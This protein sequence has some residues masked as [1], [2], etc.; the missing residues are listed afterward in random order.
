MGLLP[1]SKFAKTAVERLDS[2]RYVI[3]VLSK[4]VSLHMRTKTKLITTACVAALALCAPLSSWAKE[5]KSVPFHGKIS[6][7]DQTAK[8]FSIAGKE[9][10]RVFTITE[11][12]VITKDGKPGT[13]ADLAAEEEVRGSY[14]KR[15]DG[16]IEAKIVKLGQK[17]EAETSKSKKKKKEKTDSET[18]TA[19]SP[20]P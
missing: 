8:T 2:T 10:A 17:T 13:M 14:W 6:A 5:K 19:P 16:S 7:V 18:V 4:A 1:G 9:K 11:A 20:K 15:E 3:E 12:T